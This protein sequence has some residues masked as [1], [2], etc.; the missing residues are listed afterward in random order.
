M[1]EVLVGATDDV[2]IRHCN[3]VDAAAR[4]LQDMDAVEG[5]DVPDLRTSSGHLVLGQAPQ[6]QGLQG[7]GH[8]PPIPWEQPTHPLGRV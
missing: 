5:P 4:G 7:F 8:S 2:V 3:R 1:D 6:P